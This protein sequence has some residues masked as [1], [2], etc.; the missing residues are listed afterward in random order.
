MAEPFDEN[1]LTM[2]ISGP[3]ACIKECVNC[4][5]GFEFL[6]SLPDSQWMW[7]T[8]I[9]LTEI[10]AHVLPALS[11]TWGGWYERDSSKG[12]HCVPPPVVRSLTAHIGTESPST[13]L[14]DHFLMTGVLPSRS[15][16]HSFHPF[17]G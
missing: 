15:V 3:N 11:D 8:L 17:A 6:F 13:E 7:E 10:L 1:I 16:V 5:R 2:Q 4:I 12:T 9:L 14:E